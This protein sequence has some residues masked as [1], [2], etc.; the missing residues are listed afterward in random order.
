MDLGLKDARVFVAASSSGLGAA[1]A[2]RF[3][4]EGAAV[5]VNGRYADKLEA[6]ASAIRAASGGRVIAVPGDVLEPAAITAMI[7]R[8][9]SELGGLDVLVTNAGGPP[10]GNFD[11]LS[12]DAWE[13]GFRLTFMS[14]VHLIRA[15]LPYLRQSS[16]AVILTVTSVSVKE[17]IDNLLLS[18]SYRMGVIGL[19]K[20]LARELGPQGIRVNSI[21]PGWTRTGRVEEL[22]QS[23][24]QA[25]GISVEQ[26]MAN[27][28]AGTPLGRMG[29]PDE[30]ANVA[31][32]LCSPAASYV[33]GAMVPVD[34][35]SIRASL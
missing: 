17:P 15:A 27:Q 13:K 35:G 29:E 11:S 14:N 19:T 3:S 16:R 28:A 18:N 24:A 10:A 30:F 8:A 7:D 26:A 23:R 25:Q 22:M 1:A 12:L 9:A 34:G 5:A 20:T 6:T 21:L 31:V 33:H 4:L 32:F 2:R